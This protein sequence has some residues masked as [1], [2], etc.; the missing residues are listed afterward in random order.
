M[1]PV[2]FEIG[3]IGVQ[4]YYVIWSAALCVAM[5]WTNKR[6]DK[7]GLPVEE[8]TSVITWSF[9]AMLLG[10]RVFEYFAEWRAYFDNPR[11]FLDLE[12]GGLS[13][14]GAIAGAVIAAILL[15]RKKNISFWR[16]SD[17][18]SPAI[19]LTIAIGRW[20]CYLNGCCGG[21][22]HPV[23]LYYSFS[24]AGILALVLFIENRVRH[25]G[26]LFKYSVLS[27]IGL[28]VYSCSRLL[29]DPLRFDAATRG[30]IVT[31]YLL[32]ACAVISF[33][34]FVIS[35]VKKVRLLK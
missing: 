22:G 8:S 10:A 15:C 26:V 34:W 30:L 11:L 32:I 20:G 4:S 24:A 21:H 19:L 16:F 1:Y 31:H 33:V 27:P 7:S 12:R 14:I 25:S 5:L 29:I 28:G 35:Y 18:V 23:Q 13:E 9:A 17:T 6:I 2:L 3:G